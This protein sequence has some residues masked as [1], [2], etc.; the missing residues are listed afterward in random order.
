M[1]NSNA[2]KNIEADYRQS[3][4]LNISVNP[5]FEFNY[6]CCQKNCEGVNF[7]SPSTKCVCCLEY[8]QDLCYVFQRRSIS[9]IHRASD[10]SGRYTSGSS[11]SIFRF[12]TR[13]PIGAALASVDVWHISIYLGSIHSISNFSLDNKSLLTSISFESLNRGLGT[14]G[15]VFIFI[16]NTKKYC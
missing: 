15:T 13:I 2:N 11:T 12:L 3:L 8:A 1:Q 16:V 5:M 4:V 7:A 9:N 14:S 6:I 10:V